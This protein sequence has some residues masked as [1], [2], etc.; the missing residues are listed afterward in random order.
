[1]FDEEPAASGCQAGS[2]E[3]VVGGGGGVGYKE[4][5]WSPDREQPST[6]AKKSIRN[7]GDAK[8]MQAVGSAA[9]E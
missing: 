8:E 4:T 5:K 6:A 9:E 2:G 7:D 1:M 3:W